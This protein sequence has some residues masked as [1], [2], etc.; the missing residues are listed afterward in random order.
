ML[1]TGTG[2]GEYPRRTLDEKL[3]ARAVEQFGACCCYR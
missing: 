3:L 1:V 2:R